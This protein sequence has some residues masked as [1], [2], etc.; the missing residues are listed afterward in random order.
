M[1]T[2]YELYVEAVDAY[3]AT[4]KQRS[5]PLSEDVLELITDAHL[6]A[7]KQQLNFHHET[8]VCSCVEDVVHLFRRAFHAR[9]SGDAAQFM[10]SDGFII[11]ETHLWP[12]V[13]PS[14]RLLRAHDL[15]GEALPVIHAH[16]ARQA[17]EHKYPMSYRFI[18]S[19]LDTCTRTRASS[20]RKPHRRKRSTKAV[21]AAPPAAESAHGEPVPR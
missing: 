20:P 16:A 18:D 9:C 4:L 6:V 19:Q 12:L 7:R 17:F 8:C 13:S 5:Q 14:E 2:F 3:A 1:S 11:L 15:I 10:E 21:I